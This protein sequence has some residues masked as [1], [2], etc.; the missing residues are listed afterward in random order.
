MTWEQFLGDK[1]VADVILREAI[2]EN[3]VF[4]LEQYGIKNP[5]DAQI[6][7]AAVMEE[8]GASEEEI[9]AT[10]QDMGEVQKLFSRTIEKIDLT[11]QTDFTEYANNP[12]KAIDKLLNEKSGY[13]SNA[14]YKEGIGYI[15]F[16]YG[17]GGKDGYG[18]AHIIERRERDNIDIDK[19]IR[20]IPNIINDGSVYT[21]L[22]QKGRK[23]VI[24]NDKEVIIRLD[25]DGE[26]RNWLLTAYMKKSGALPLGLTSEQIRSDAQT[27]ASNSASDENITT[28]NENVKL[29]SRNRGAYTPVSRI[30]EIAKEHTPDTFLHEVS[31]NFFINYF[32]AIERIADKNSDYVKQAQA[33]YDLVGKILFC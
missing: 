6:E 27:P 30:I 26:Q 5:T 13:V 18:L 1:Q 3:P 10:L 29:Y 4:G 8:N 9:R 14:M 21:V 28:N 15:D 24:S 23:F 16:I 2:G 19:F 7:R 32:D 11:N 22:G 33:V 17:K 25:L 20:Q 12:E 31:H